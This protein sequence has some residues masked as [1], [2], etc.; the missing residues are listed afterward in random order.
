MG[1][2]TYYVWYAADAGRESVALT[3]A[4]NPLQRIIHVAPFDNSI[5]A[6]INKRP[7][8]SLGG[9]LVVAVDQINVTDHCDHW[10]RV[11]LHDSQRKAVQP[12]LSDR[13]I[14]SHTYRQDRPIPLWPAG[15][16]PAVL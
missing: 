7:T 5:A 11:P 6:I 1:I 15:R 10:L 12:R 8:K 4:G 3:H 16:W 2:L 14:Q 13:Q 9:P